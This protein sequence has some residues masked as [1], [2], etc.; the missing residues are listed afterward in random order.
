M[1][2]FGLAGVACGPAGEGPA[3]PAKIAV[4]VQ[5]P[6]PTA[7]PPADPAA[8]SLPDKPGPPPFTCEGGLARS[9]G[10]RSYCAYT[11]TLSWTDAEKRCVGR[12]GHLVS[13][14]S[15]EASDALR[16]TFGNALGIPMRAVWIGLEVVNKAKKQWR[17]ST[18]EPVKLDRWSAGEPNDYEGHESC[19]ELLSASGKW[20]DTRCDLEQGFVCQAVGQRPLDCSGGR[21]LITPPGKYCYVAEPATYAVAKRSCSKRG[22]ALASITTEE[23]A[24][25]IGDTL[26]QRLEVSRFWIGL[27][28]LAEQGIWAWVDGSR[29]GRS[30]WIPGEPNDFGREGCV[31]LHT[32][33]WRWNDLDCNAQLA[34][35]CEPSAVVR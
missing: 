17:W 2:L 27:S 14:P 1:I 23:V 30:E 13:L 6:Q 22:G 5:P 4:P 28:D 19:G 18:G 34:S 12:G 31:E 33:V 26:E 8:S 7:A 29:F 3:D 32:D 15:K 16:A 25:E 21:G 20:N 9:V 35:V 10:G 24:K 11:D